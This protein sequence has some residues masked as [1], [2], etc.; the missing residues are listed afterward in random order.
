MQPGEPRDQDWLYELIECLTETCL[1]LAE[2]PPN[3]AA[4]AL[5]SRLDRAID[6]CHP[7]EAGQSGGQHPA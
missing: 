2:A 5:R 3:E 7:H 6:V 1:K 4:L